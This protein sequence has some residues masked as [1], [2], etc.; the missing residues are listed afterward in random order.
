MIDNV[1]SKTVINLS[2]LKIGNEKN[3]GI[4]NIT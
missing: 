3:L 4:G 1:T 2:L